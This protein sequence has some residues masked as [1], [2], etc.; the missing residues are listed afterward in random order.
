MERPRENLRFNFLRTF[1]NNLEMEGGSENSPNHQINN[2][3][4]M[5]DV[6]AN[7]ESNINQSEVYN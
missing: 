7:V 1:K 3:S 6:D 2:S 5:P 4:D